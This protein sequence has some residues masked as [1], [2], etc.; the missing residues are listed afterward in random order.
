[1]DLKILSKT[2][3]KRLKLVMSKIITSNQTAYVKD[4][5]IGEAVRLISDILETTEEMDIGALLVTIDFQKAFDS[6]NHVFIIESCRKFG[7]PDEMLSWIELLLKN[8]ESCVIN[9][10][11]TTKYFNLERGARQG[12]PIAA[13]LF[14]IAL[15][16][17]FIMIKANNEIKPLELC[18]TAF[19][20]SAYADD[21]SLYLKDEDSVRALFATIKIFSSY[22]DLKPNYSKCEIAG[23]GALKGVEWALCGLKSVDLTQSTIKIL[24]LHFSYNEKLKNEKNFTDTVSKIENLLRVWRLRNLTLEGK[25]TIFKTLAISGVVYNAYLS[26]VPDYVITA[27]KKIQN[28]F[29]WDGKKAKIK[30]DTLCN[31]YEKGGLQSVDIDFKFKALQLSWIKRL[32]DSNDHQWKKIPLFFLKKFLASAT[33]FIHSFRQRNH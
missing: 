31:F 4:R 7:I 13:Y 21:V 27:L 11:T 28:N 33:L 18:D 25:I 30:H 26:G 22:S 23:I 2:L 9:A 1:V 10:G 19:L 12:D 29:L 6:L 3:A 24:G 15:E 5:F 17:L 8:Q 14:I 16:M 20:Y 32:Y